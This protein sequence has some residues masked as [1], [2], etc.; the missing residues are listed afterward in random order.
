[1]T[2]AAVILSGCGHTDG[3]E[4]REAVLS[5]LALDQRGVAVEMFAPDIPQKHVYDCLNNAELS[6]SRNVLQEAA[7]IARGQIQPLVECAATS[8]DMLVIPG[9]FGVAKN[10]SN[11]A[12]KGKDAEILPAFASIV[13]D[14]FAQKKPIA[15]L[16]IAPAVLAV[17]LKDAGITVTIGE[18]AG[19]AAAIEACGNIHQQAPSHEAVIDRQHRIATCSAYMREDAI[20]PIAKGIDACIAAAVEMAAQAKQHAA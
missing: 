2:R 1:M 3:A 14:F 8:F 13:R 20:S 6:P 4:I 19:C 16:C 17:T 10:L 15:A 7:R 12:E 5:L 9:G 18:D 11:F